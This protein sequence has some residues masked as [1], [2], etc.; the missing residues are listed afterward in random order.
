[1]SVPSP[2]FT[3]CIDVYDDVNGNDVERYCISVTLS[4]ETLPVTPGG[5]PATIYRF[6]KIV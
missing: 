4:T 1:M 2:S 5:S 6:G 3:F